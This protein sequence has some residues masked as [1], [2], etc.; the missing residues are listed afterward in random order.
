MKFI[1]LFTLVITSAAV[2]A[3]SKN[4][5]QIRS[6]LD[7]Q[8]KAWNAG[9]IEEFMKGYW[10]NDSLMFIGSN[11]ITYG[12]EAT[13]KSYHKRYPNRDAMGELTFTILNVQQLSAN[14]FHVIGKWFLKREKAGDIGGHF[15]L[16]WKKIKGR[17]VI[18][19]DHSS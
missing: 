8:T 7:A 2:A 16:L 11:G 1:L 19:A 4:E 18:V 15:T 3:Q 17:W 5:Q 9:N 6:I 14:S 12:Y 13:L 10:Q